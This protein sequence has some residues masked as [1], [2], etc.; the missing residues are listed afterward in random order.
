MT[1]ASRMQHKI[2]WGPLRKPVEW[3][4]KTFLAPWS[5]IASV[6]YHDTFWYPTH[7]QIV[8]QLLHSEWGRLFNNWEKVEIP[9]G[10][11]DAEGW[12]DVGAAPAELRKE[13]SK[14]LLRSFRVLGSCIR[15]APE[16]EA[17]KRRLKK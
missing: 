7:Q 14:L 1:F 9:P 13:S 12:P 17:R 11:L 3:S 5:Y 4:L 16:F 8:H 15:E 2:Y 10:I 6:L